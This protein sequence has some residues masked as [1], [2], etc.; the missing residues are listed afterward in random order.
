[1]PAASA[2]LP[3]S[4]FTTRAPSRVPSVTDRACT[5]SEA[6]TAVP[7]LISCSAT[8]RAVSTGMANPSP[9]DPPVVPLPPSEAMAVLMPTTAPVPSTSA[10]PELPGL[11]GAS[12]W[13][14]LITALVSLPS[15][16]SRT[17][18]S[19][20]LTMPLVTVPAR[21]SGEPMAT[22]GSPTTTEPSVASDAATSP[23][24]S[25]LMTAMSLAGSRPTM[26]ASEPLPSENTARI[27]APST[28]SAPE[29]TW[30][31]VTM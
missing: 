1:M 4:T 9:I 26:R 24:F 5:P 23:G 19:R 29:T 25:T 30:L 14:A 12:V 28:P 8:V 21:P 31:L 15:P 22:T 13:I 10:P 3:G 18:R 20:A 2:G 6:C 27:S 16:D 17:G 11:I 7:V